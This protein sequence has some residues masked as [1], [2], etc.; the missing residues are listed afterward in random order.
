MTFNRTCERAFRTSVVHL[1]VVFVDYYRE[2]VERSW[3]WE[4]DSRKIGERLDF[5]VRGFNTNCINNITNYRN[6]ILTQ[7][8][9]AAAPGHGYL[10][11]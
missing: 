7:P 4:V 3:K 11:L 9:A 10:Q 8:A 2:G 1:S 5:D 6:G